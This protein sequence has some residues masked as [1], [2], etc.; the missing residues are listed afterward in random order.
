MNGIQKMK[1]S[2]FLWISKFICLPILLFILFLYYSWFF[3]LKL[4]VLILQYHTVFIMYIFDTSSKAANST[5]VEK[6][7]I[8]CSL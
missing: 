8:K 3:F 7:E 2:V 6:R 4:T 1:H 5:K